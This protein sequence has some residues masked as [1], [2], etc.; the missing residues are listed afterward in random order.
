MKISLRKS[1]GHVDWIRLSFLVQWAC[2]ELI[3]LDQTPAGISLGSVRVFSNASPTKHRF[4]LLKPIA[5]TPVEAVKGPR[6][7]SAL[8]AKSLLRI[9]S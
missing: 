4:T 8:S 9:M 7:T 1:S 2:D 3:N 6:Q 5:L